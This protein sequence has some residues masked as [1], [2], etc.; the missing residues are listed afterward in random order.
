MEDEF[1]IFCDNARIRYDVTRKLKR[2]SKSFNISDKMLNKGEL[3]STID[4]T[5]L[6]WEKDRTDQANALLMKY[7]YN[8]DNDSDLLQLP[9]T[10][11]NNINPNF[12]AQLDK[13]ERANQK[14]QT[15][16][17]RQADLAK[18]RE[19]QEREEKDKMELENLKNK[20]KNN[21]SRNKKT[22]KN[23]TAPTNVDDNDCEDDVNANI[24]NDNIIQEIKETKSKKKNDKKKKQN[25][26]WIQKYITKLQWNE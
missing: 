16:L 19:Q 17:Q 7:Q 14:K 12:L 21:Y 24:S 2:I 4:E 20:N 10:N 11:D 3:F 15:I 13:E 25:K 23:I 26:K 8:C 22:K 1:K 9:L 6:L 18:K 5:D